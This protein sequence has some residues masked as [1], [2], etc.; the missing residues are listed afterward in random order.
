MGEGSANNEEYRAG[1]LTLELLASPVTHKIINVLPET[2]ESGIPKANL[3]AVGPA[4]ARVDRL[5]EI[6]RLERFGLV[7]CDGSTVR[8]TPATVDLMEAW[9]LLLGWGRIGWLR[10]VLRPESEDELRLALEVHR[11]W[12]GEILVQLAIKPSGVKELT[13]RL[14]G[15]SLSTV[16]RLV[17][18]AHEAELLEKRLTPSGSAGY[19]LTRLGCLLV[20][21]MSAVFRSEEGIP[22]YVTL[23]PSMD[24]FRAGLA[25]AAQ[26]LT[27]PAGKDRDILFEVLDDRERPMIVKR[28]RFREG[29]LAEL[30][31]SPH[32]ASLPCVAGTVDAW[33]S[34]FIK[35]DAAG[36]MAF[37]PGAK[38][39]LRQLRRDL[40]F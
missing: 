8:G 2:G 33:L 31:P 4:R 25:V 5:A 1:D 32:T 38:G 19:H 6:A 40:A 18:L 34:L 21:P 35:R 30:T 26:L 7:A 39:A 27:L 23:P 22:G 13:D 3:V 11:L 37:N 29:A 36:M 10:E 14:N 9:N 17:K 20:R 12:A 28:A 24:V 16:K 15:P